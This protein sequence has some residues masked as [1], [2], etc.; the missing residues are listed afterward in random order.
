[1]KGL[2]G[3]KELG[4]KEAI[5]LDPCNSIHTLF[6]AFPIDI[7]F[8]DRENK[9]VKRIFAL[10]PFRLTPIVW[11][12]KRAIELPAGTIQSTQTADYDTIIFE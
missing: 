6:M 8:L 7:L 1:M 11:H 10:K 12:A 4:A 5:I 2:L 9:V 3:R